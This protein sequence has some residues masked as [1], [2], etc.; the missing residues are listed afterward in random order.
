MA[1]NRNQRKSSSSFTG[2]L[3]G[4]VMVVG[5]LMVAW[6]AISGI[7]NILA[8]V[9]PV[10]FIIT[11]VLKWQV[12]LDYGKFIVKTFQ[13]NPVK[14]L[15]YGAGTFFGFPLVAA[16]LF[17]KALTLSQVEKRFG[18]K[19]EKYAEYEEVEEQEV[20]EEDFLDLP[21]IEKANP[22]KKSNNEYED[23]F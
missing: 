11:L 19:E 9:A 5:V 12:V 18:K 8:W 16:Y 22:V 4:I 17:F 1:N 13:E 14:G 10:L 15:L 21:E 2:S 6:F 7:F 23:L 20:D 3:L